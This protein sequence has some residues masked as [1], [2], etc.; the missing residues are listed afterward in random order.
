METRAQ[1]HLPLEHTHAVV[2]RVE[3]SRSWSS[4]QRAR[5]TRGDLGGRGLVLSLLGWGGH[6]ADHARK[7]QGA[8]T[9]TLVVTLAKTSHMRRTGATRWMHRA[10]AGSPIRFSSTCMLHPS[11][12][13]GT[14]RTTA[15]VKLLAQL[16]KCKPGALVFV[17]PEI[18]DRDAW[19]SPD[20]YRQH[21]PR[22]G[23][24]GH[25]FWCPSKFC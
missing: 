20:Q 13:L 6:D 1:L 3:G 8:N 15:P 19:Q 24:G 7:C 11:Q 10:C 23:E 12:S 5:H 9:C 21:S 16:T 4:R 25:N 22:R 2:Q 18:C 17:Y 14:C